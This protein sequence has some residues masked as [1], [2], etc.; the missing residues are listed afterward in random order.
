LP[1]RHEGAVGEKP[2]PFRHFHRM[3][4]KAFV[5][6]LYPGKAE[7]YRKR[8]NPIW[9]ELAEM[10]RAHG[11]GA[12]SIFLHPGTLQL[13]ACAEIESE[14]RWQAIAQT[15]ICQRWW[16]Y[17]KDLMAANPD[18]RPKV[19]AIEEVFSLAQQES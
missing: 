18:A 17:M 9:P 8:H 7:E 2:S 10:L 3:I 11:V 13:F 16:A 6:Q 1:K 19:I 5:M 15:E 12:Y 4:R 14:E